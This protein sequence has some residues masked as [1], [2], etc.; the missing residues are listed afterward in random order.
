MTLL[1]SVHLVFISDEIQVSAPY[2]H[3]YMITIYETKY[4]ATSSRSLYLVHSDDVLM[5]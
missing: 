1:H 5:V 4:M 3:E 2:R